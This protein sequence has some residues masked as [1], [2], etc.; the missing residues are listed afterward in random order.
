MVGMAVFAGLLVGGLFVAKRHRRRYGY[1][2]GRCGHSRMHRRHGRH[3]HNDD[4]GRRDAGPMWVLFDRL[5]TTP[6][7]E[8][9]IRAEIRGLRDRAKTLRKERDRTREDLASAMRGDSF[10]EVVMG[11]MFARHDDVLRELRMDA[12]GAL[13]RIHEA[14]EPEQRGRLASFLESGRRPFWGGP[15]RSAW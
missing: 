7:Q 9:A 11:E 1:A 10:D 4:D 13:V 8:K 3:G 12:V 2:G 15:Y 14:L 6:G 5:D